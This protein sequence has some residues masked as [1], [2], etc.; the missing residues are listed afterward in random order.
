MT[1][2]SVCPPAR[3]ASSALNCIACIGQVGNL[4]HENISIGKAGRKRHMGMPSRLSAV[5]S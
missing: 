5:P 1:L 3:S 2:R 4:E